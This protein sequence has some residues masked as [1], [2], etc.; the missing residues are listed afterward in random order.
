[1][2]TFQ[3]LF[4]LPICSVQVAKDIK[5]SLPPMFEMDKIKR[6]FGI[7][8][9]PTTIVLLQEL[10]RF[11]KLIKRMKLSLI[12]LGRALIGK[13]SNLKFRVFNL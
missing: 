12:E 11:N 10:E 9:E 3:L 6:K 13:F 4:I 1:M 8:I 7:D 2:I 5:D